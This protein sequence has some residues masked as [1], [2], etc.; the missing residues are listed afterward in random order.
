MQSK[1]LNWLELGSIIN[2][3]VK[4]YPSD[5]VHDGAIFALNVG[6][7]FYYQVRKHGTHICRTN[8]KDMVHYFRHEQE[9]GRRYFRLT[10][11]GVQNGPDI[12]AVELDRAEI[13]LEA[14]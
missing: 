12:E 9:E 1:T 10:V 7:S 5:L 11:K 4:H 8:N 3:T 6:K 2:Q 14:N 13:T